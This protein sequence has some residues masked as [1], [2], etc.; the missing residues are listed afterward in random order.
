MNLGDAFIRRKQIATE[1]Q[2]WTNRL[3]LAGKD[4]TQYYTKSIETPPY[5]PIPGTIK[6]YKRTYTIEECR[7]K[8][9]TLIK[10]DLV[11]SHRISLTN[12]NASGTFQDLDGTVRTLTIPA[13]LVLR[14]DIAPKLE[15]AARAIPVKA[16]GVEVTGTEDG[17][18]KW[19]NITQEYKH[20]Q[21]FNDKGMKAENDVID[22]YRIEETVD[23]GWNERDVFDEIDK[24]HEWLQRIKNA[25]N[26]ANKTEL[27]DVET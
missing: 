7:A 20:V 18:I 22:R 10:E 8:L 19:R 23:Y 4:T 1:I 17:L 6:E 9:D 3:Q 15:A 26:E 24:I 27:V 21:E 11:L 12:Q 16:K 2:T 25:I 13:L 5:E 14:N